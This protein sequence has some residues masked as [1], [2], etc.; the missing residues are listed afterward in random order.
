MAIPNSKTEII[1]AIKNNYSKLKNDLEN[2]PIA[3]TDAQEMD[4]HAKGTKM[5]VH[6]LVSYLVGWGELVLKWHRLKSN[7]TTIIFPERG[8]KW[9]ELGKLAQKFYS[10]YE[11]FDYPELLI[12]LDAVVA[13]ILQ[14]VENTSNN[15]LYHKPWYGKWT[16]GR[17]IQLNTSSPYKN[18]RTRVRKWKRLKEKDSEQ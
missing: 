7:N 18:T 4:G 11:D 8:Y 3:W 2:I 15:E 9:N 14:L 1:A 12:K 13:E 6:N 17:M 16:Q 5:S 10:D